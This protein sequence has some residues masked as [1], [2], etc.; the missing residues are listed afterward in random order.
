MLFPSYT[1]I[2][3]LVLVV[4]VHLVLPRRARAMF[5]LLAS[6][7]FYLSW[8]PIYGLLLGGMTVL[9]FGIGRAIE[10]DRARR[11]L[12]LAIGCIVSLGALAFFKYAGFAAD[13]YN[14]L[15]AHFGPKGTPPLAVDIVLPLGI[16]FFTFQMVSYVT[17]VYRGDKAEASLAN[18]AL[19]VTFFAQLIAGPIVRADELLPQLTSERRVDP[20]RFADGMDLL[21]RGYLKKMVIAD[22]LAVVSDRVFANPAAYGTAAT[23]IGVLCY[24][25]QIYGDF[26]GYTDIARGAGLMLGFELPDNFRLPYLSGSITD[27]W[28]RWH[29]TLSR[30]LRDYL[31]IPLGGNRHGTAR[32]YV[33]LTITMG[34]GGLWHGASWTFMIWGLYHGLLLAL[35]KAWT[36]LLRRIGLGG[37]AGSRAYHAV[38]VLCTFALVCAGWVVFRAPDFTTAMRVYANVLGMT[39]VATVWDAEFKRAA[40]FLV[41]ALIGHGLGNSAMLK[42]RW[43]EVS[44]VPRGLAWAGLVVAFY[45]FA[46]R[47]ADFIYFQF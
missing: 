8:N 32:R 34:L 23:C 22:N 18:Y 42:A 6:Y 5:L 19:Y 40:V 44:P 10:R 12:W 39:E 11:G 2:A 47:P 7:V 14:W 1:F 17:D 21:L 33:N 45:L 31:Y 4:G 16:S 36:L 30:W 43:A 24:A 46:G 26:S 15:M 38:A 9:T 41:A 25:G 28:R 3:F 29:I 37:L 13:Q 35:H 27:F 20:A